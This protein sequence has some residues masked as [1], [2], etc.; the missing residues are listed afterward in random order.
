[1]SST[2][3]HS[4]APETMKP[5][6]LGSSAGHGF[7][8]IRVFAFALG[9]ALAATV[10]SAGGD[11]EGDSDQ[12]MLVVASIKPVHSLVS[13]VMAGV[14]APHLIIRGAQSPHTFSMRPSDAAALAKARVIFLIDEHK[15]VALAGPIANLGDEALV[16]Q[17][18]GAEGLVLK[19]LREGGAYEAHDHGEQDAAE[20]DGEE[21]DHDEDEAGHHEGDDHDEDEEDHHDEDDHDDDEDEHRADDDQHE[22]DAH[23]HGHLHEH[24]DVDFHIWLDPENAVLMTYAIVDAL[25]E[26]DPENAATYDA[27]AHALIDRLDALLAEIDAELA[28]IRD[29]PYIVLHDAYRY[30]EERFDLNAAGSITINPERAP[31]VQRIA[32]IRDKVRDLGS[33]CVFAEPQFDSRVIDVVT[34]GTD[35][36]SGT[37][38]PLGAAIEDGP[39][40]YFTLIRDLAAAFK[41]CLAAA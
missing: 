9:F 13:A 35:A 21:A 33:V 20:R 29:K 16:V 3:G 26:A 25:I 7:R 6:S 37:I 31:G 28:P 10:A 30:F 2:Q 18:A 24:G 1:M 23:D 34:E 38:D 17:L 15:E 41:E 27:N 39:E 36:R 5:G 12:T 19:P 8:T 32:E 14:G 22:G 4:V 40:L 11:G